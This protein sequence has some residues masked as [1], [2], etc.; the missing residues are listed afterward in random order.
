MLVSRIT[1][2]LDRALY[3]DFGDNWDDDM[4]R[5]ILQDKINSQA[6][7]LDYGAGRGNVKQMN[8]KDIARFVAG[9]DAE[10]AVFENPFLHEAKL[11]DLTNSI[12]PYADNTFDVVF[13]DNVIEHV[14][15]PGV[16]FK[17]IQRVLKPGGV[18]LA[19]TPNK[20]H[21]M[22]VIARIAPT[23]FHRFYNK[24]RGRKCI[25]TF[26]TFYKCNT[27]A[28]VVKYAEKAGFL[29]KRIEFIEGRPE[30]LRLTAL[31]Y[32]CGYLYERIVNFSNKFACFRC[33][34][35]FEL[36]KE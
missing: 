27:R 34:M 16:V 11:L 4:F 7:C 31:T 13:S 23:W 20:R 36:S 29:V 15:N 6:T 3:P 21:Y 2:H 33:V 12:I 5:K 30:Y 26:P 18:F 17:E 22:P 24:L 1:E 14:E 25:D 35:I 19:K 28:S 10:K 8:F 9:I 32:L